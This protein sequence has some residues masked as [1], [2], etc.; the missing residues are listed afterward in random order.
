MSWWEALILGLVQGLTEFLPVSSSGHLE[1]GKVILNAEAETDITFTIV[2]HGAT[3]LST[4]V[5]FATEIWRIIRGAIRFQWNSEMQ[6]VG[7]IA[8]SMIPVVLVG[9][10]LQDFV[11]GF[12]T[13]NLVF[14]GSMLLVTSL[15][16]SLTWFMRNK[17]EGKPLTWWSALIMGLAQALATLPGISRSGATIATGLL[18]GR[19]KQQVAQFSFLMVLIPIIGVNVI[20]LLETDGT[21]LVSSTGWFPLMVGFIGA[22]LSG[23]FACAWMVN[24][25]KRGKLIGFA[26]YCLIVGALALGFGI[27]A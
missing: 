24:L 8:I 6:Y 4:V 27:F 15:L 26:I 3:L 25:V 14:V 16:L 17:R 23:W 22:F 2:V 12:F 9:L 21:G 10:F 7:M 1:L 11:E 18:M 5:V 13:G 19:N 20:K